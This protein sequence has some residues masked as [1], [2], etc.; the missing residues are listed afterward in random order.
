M[1]KTFTCLFFLLIF[2]SSNSYS[3][4][5]FDADGKWSTSFEYGQECVKHWQFHDDIGYCQHV[6][7]DGLYWL[8]WPPSYNDDIH[9]MDSLTH[10]KYGAANTGNYSARFW[11]WDGTNRQSPTVRV[12]FPQDQPE[13]WIRWYQRWQEGFYWESVHYDKHLY[14]WPSNGPAIIP[15]LYSGRF[16]IAIVGETHDGRS[17]NIMSS[18]YYED[19]VGNPSRGEYISIEIYLK[20]NSEMG[21][22]DGI[23]RMWVNGELVLDRADLNIAGS[24]ADALAGINRFTF[25]HNQNRIGNLLGP[26]GVDGAYVD[27]DDMVIYTQTPPNVDAHGNSFIG[28]IGWDGSPILLP[29]KLLP[30]VE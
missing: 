22:A 30:V 26:L 15:G 28:P 25:D 3:T 9:T 12:R 2:F 27:V 23:A 11:K 10:V 5:T 17:Q 6:A 16:Y 8:E 1:K 7:N 20:T 29:P 18:A 4:I 19:V 14:M 13:L 24:Q 21:V